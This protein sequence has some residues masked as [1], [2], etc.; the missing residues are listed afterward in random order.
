MQQKVY[1]DNLQQKQRTRYPVSMICVQVLDNIQEIGVWGTC[2]LQRSWST[3]PQRNIQTWRS[4]WKSNCI[5]VCIYYTVGCSKFTWVKLLKIL[6]LWNLYFQIFFKYQVLKTYP[7]KM[8]PKSAM[9]H[10]G[11]L[12]PR[13]ATAWC[14]WRPKC[15]KPLAASWTSA[16]YCS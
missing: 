13:I 4:I 5:W 15:M 16:K 1:K 2:K 6:N 3:F 11:E 14:L 9:T 8:A 12:G 7:A 10:S